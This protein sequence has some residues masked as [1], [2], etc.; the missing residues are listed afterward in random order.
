MTLTEFEDSVLKLELDSNTVLYDKMADYSDGDDT[1]SNFK[2]L[3]EECDLTH[4]KIWFVY[5]MKH[6]QAIRSYVVGGS[7]E[8]EPIRGRIV[9]AINYLKILNGMV[10]EA[11]KEMNEW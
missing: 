11:D 3:A 1:F 9:D 6:I 2:Q 10:E 8:S 4:F 5:F 7:V